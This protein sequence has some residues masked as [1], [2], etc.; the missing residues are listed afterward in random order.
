[1]RNMILGT[2]VD[3]EEISR[4]YS[5]D[6][7]MLF[8]RIKQSLA[9][10]LEGLSHKDLL[11]LNSVKDGV[12][13]EA[14][15]PKANKKYAN[16]LLAFIANKKMDGLSIDSP[17]TPLI[18]KAV[19]DE[20][21]AFYSDAERVGE[22]LFSM[23]KQLSEIR[24]EFKMHEGLYDNLDMQKVMELRG[25]SGQAGGLVKSALGKF[26]AK[27]LADAIKQV[28]SLL[29][30]ATYKAV[31]VNMG[32]AVF[33]SGIVSF[34]KPIVLAV[35]VKV[36][37][38]AIAKAAVA[39]ALWVVIGVGAVTASVPAAY[40]LLPAILALLSYE[41]YSLPKKLAAKLPKEITAKLAAD[42]E[43]I[44]IA[45]TAEMADSLL[46]ELEKQIMD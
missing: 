43:A 15:Q 8:D 21:I 3:A 44:N 30:K 19:E 23:E 29:E 34:I 9:S 12:V 7:L 39:K 25:V 24:D 42:F 35:L 33:S 46:Q 27:S 45:I 13:Q 28:V 20:F 16:A 2:L 10:Q 1:M 40:V 22:V 32:N 11:A 41:A 4:L 5:K 36:G 38:A 14:L 37:I 31:I 26:S 18:T 6:Q 17:L